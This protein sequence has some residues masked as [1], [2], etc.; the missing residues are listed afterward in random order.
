MQLW[1]NRV[2]KKLRFKKSFE[3]SYLLTYRNFEK[4]F[5]NIDKYKNNHFLEK[6]Y[7][8]TFLEIFG[9]TYYIFLCKYVKGNATCQS[10][11]QST[12]NKN[13]AVDFINNI[14]MEFL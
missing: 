7:N 6:Y 4:T 3:K 1:K 2:L 12:I 13:F 8:L 9:A 5:K 14:S 10:H 11:N